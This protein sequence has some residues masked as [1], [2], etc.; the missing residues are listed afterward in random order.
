M[1]SDWRGICAAR[2]IFILGLYSLMEK[3]IA[4]KVSGIS[5][6]FRIPASPAGGPHE[7]IST[8]RGAFV[9]ALKMKE[10]GLF[11]GI[12]NKIAT[13]DKFSVFA[14]ISSAKTIRSDPSGHGGFLFYNF[15]F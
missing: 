8:L 3:E 5:K 15:E 11:C 14:I 6:T 1:L 10:S 7:K 13:L 9:N 2:N 4:I 12:I